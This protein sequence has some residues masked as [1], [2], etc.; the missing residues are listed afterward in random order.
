MS[1]L[2]VPG[3]RELPMRVTT[4]RSA[5]AVVLAVHGELDLHTHRLLTDEAEALLAQP[6]PQLRHLIVDLS[7]QTFCDSSG[8][9]ALI[10][11]RQRAAAAGLLTTLVGAHGVMERILHRTGLDYV[12]V[13]YQSAADA[14]RALGLTLPRLPAQ[15]NTP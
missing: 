9:G 15:D 11:I 8:L 5:S 7:Q 12:F 4:R 6:Q 2:R 13:C 14:E 1:L 10:V 3:T